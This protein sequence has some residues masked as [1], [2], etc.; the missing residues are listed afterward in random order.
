MS[1]NESRDENTMKPDKVMRGPPRIPT[2]DLPMANSN[3]RIF[4]KKPSATIP[5]PLNCTKTVGS[6]R[7]LV[8]QLVRCWGLSLR[9]SPVLSVD[10]WREIG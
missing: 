3:S 4:L 10:L 1:V 7:L 9:I 8:V 5:M 6:T 2:T